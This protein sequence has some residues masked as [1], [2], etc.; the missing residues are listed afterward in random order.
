[1][2]LY[3][4]FFCFCIIAVTNCIPVIAQTNNATC[5][6]VANFMGKNIGTIPLNT[7]LK[8]EKLSLKHCP[9]NANKY[10]LTSY[11]LYLIRDST[12]IYRTNI[13]N[14]RPI[15]N[16]AIVT[17]ALA[18]NGDKIVFANIL[19]KGEHIERALNNFYLDVAIQMSNFSAT[20]LI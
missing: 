4:F 18:Q 3:L 7:I 19:V 2:R 12:N 17:L 1:M 16:A 8:G 9:E 14:N 5:L 6:P 11:D 10:K 20:E 15:N 13:Q